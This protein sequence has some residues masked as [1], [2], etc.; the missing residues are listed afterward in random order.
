[1]NRELHF[2]TDSLSINISD[3]GVL[4]NLYEI[5]E[6]LEILNDNSSASAMSD[7][8]LYLQ[9]KREMLCDIIKYLNRIS[10]Q[11]NEVRL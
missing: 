8:Q 9:G 10:P 3:E 5:I 7:H 4:H 2:K 11:I 6:Q 1:M